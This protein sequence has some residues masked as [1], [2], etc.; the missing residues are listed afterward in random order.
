[1][2]LFTLQLKI[3]TVNL[4]LM[5]YFDLRNS[6]NNIKS[7]KSIRRLRMDTGWSPTTVLCSCYRSL[8]ID[9]VLCKFCDYNRQRELEQT[10][11]QLQAKSLNIRSQLERDYHITESQYID[12]KSH[13]VDDLTIAD[14][15]SMR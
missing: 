9:N 3:Y 15:F 1:M 14:Y 12:L 6:T 13:S 7:S 11:K 10:N 8:A 5:L 4:I 2:T